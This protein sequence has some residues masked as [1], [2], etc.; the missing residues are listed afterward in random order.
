L[1]VVNYEEEP[2]EVLLIINNVRVGSYVIQPQE[3]LVLNVDD[4]GNEGLYVLVG[5]YL[6]RPNYVDIR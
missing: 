6:V 5:N 3:V 2:K 4:V 1:L